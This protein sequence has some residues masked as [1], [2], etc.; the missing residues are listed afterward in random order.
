M[1]LSQAKCDL[2][3]GMVGVAVWDPLSSGAQA[4]GR[5]H[6]GRT[7]GTADIVGGAGLEHFWNRGSWEILP[8]ALFEQLF[9]LPAGAVWRRGC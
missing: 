2:L 5:T 3:G 1:G 7:R 8:N 9:P 6:T 4:G